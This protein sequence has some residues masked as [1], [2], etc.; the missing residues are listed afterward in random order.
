M[1]ILLH[2]YQS[3]A[4]VSAVPTAAEQPMAAFV[5][6]AGAGRDHIRSWSDGCVLLM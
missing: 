6:V 2:S 1:R 5:H 3:L 4:A